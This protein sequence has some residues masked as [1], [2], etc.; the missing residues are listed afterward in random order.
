MNGRPDHDTRARAMKAH[1]SAEGSG[2]GDGHGWY[3]WHG[4]MM[5]ICC[6][7]M[8][9]IAVALVA[10]GMVGAGFLVFAVVCTAVMALMMRGM[11]DAA[12]HGGTT[13][14]AGDTR[15]LTCLGRSRCNV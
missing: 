2:R 15:P 13:R 5:M 11:H 9:V 4:W 14:P 6:I 10:A 3:G 8:L 12:G 7:P 1:Q